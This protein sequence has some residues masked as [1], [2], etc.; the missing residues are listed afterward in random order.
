MDIKGIKTRR[1]VPPKDSLEELLSYVDGKLG[2]KSIV[3]ISS[4]VC[5]ICTGDCIPVDSVNKQA[6]EKSESLNILTHKR[7]G[8]ILLTKKNDMLLEYGGVDTIY[9]GQYYVTL[10][11]KPYK[12]AMD[13]W[14]ILKKRNNLKHVGV[15]ITDSHSVPFRKGSIG[16]AI[17]GYGFKPTYSRVNR[18]ATADII[19]GLAASAN[20]VMGESNKHM[21]IAI[22]S[23][24]PDIKFFTKPLPPSIMRSYMYVRSNEVYD[25]KEY[26]ST[27]M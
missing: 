8:E 1:F 21:P 19:D 18:G 27:K 23:K 9:A 22:I 12:I 17:A 14:K 13:I 5:S 25:T 20:V 3:A 7:S 10:P 6:L 16:L 24:I 15:I 11:K 4:K 26:N 2:D